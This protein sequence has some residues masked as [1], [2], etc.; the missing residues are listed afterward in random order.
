ML[1]EGFHKS[2][3]ELFAL[4]KQQNTER[5]K[6]GPESML[7]NQEQLENECDKLDMLR[8][9]LCLAEKAARKGNFPRV[10][11]LCMHLNT[12]LFRKLCRSVQM[13]F[14]AG[15]IFPIIK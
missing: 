7:W 2:F 4:I 5:E 11:L 3:S 1:R 13:P 12:L 15:E 10:F 14:Q 9:Q 8:E 6:A